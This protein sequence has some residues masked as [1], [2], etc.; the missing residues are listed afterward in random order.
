MGLNEVKQELLEQAEKQAKEIVSNAKSQA[1]EI[2]SKANAEIKEYEKQAESRSKLVIETITKK[3]LASA[4]LD[5]QRLLM[6]TRKELVEN[7]MNGVVK[8]IASLKK[9]EK[10]KF[11]QD[12]L[13]AAKKEIKVDT[14]FVNKNDISL[15]SDNKIKVMTS[16]I[17]G[18]LIAETK[19]KDVSVN[20][21]V[22]ELVETAKS[23]LLINVSEVLF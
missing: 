5:S 6:N 7:V 14:V 21:S 18:G 8:N 17:E 23:E 20:L 4:K 1:E 9:T 11:L 10:K 19:E 3:M 2:K 15:L 16:N 12:L 22:E 13:N